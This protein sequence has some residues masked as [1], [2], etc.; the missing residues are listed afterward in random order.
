MIPLSIWRLY[1]NME[2]NLELYSRY[3]SLP[4]LIFFILIF[5]IFSFERVKPNKF[6]RKNLLCSNKNSALVFIGFI[7]VYFI[8]LRGYINTDW[9]AYYEAFKTI[10]INDINL[11]NE[12]LFWILCLISKKIFNEYSIFILLSTVLDYFLF[13]LAFK[14]EKSFSLCF[15]I[16]FLFSGGTGFRIEVN[17]MRNVKSILIFTISLKYLYSKNFKIY[18]LLNLIGSLF[19]I[20]SFIYLILPLFIQKKYNPKLTLFIFLVG[21]VI[22]LLQIHFLTNL[23]E[24]IS[25]LIPTGRLKFLL[26]VYLNSDRFSQSKTLSLGYLER[27][28]IFIILFHYSK[29]L[30]RQ[31]KKNL[32]LLNIS[33]LYIFCYLFCTEMIIITDRFTL[34]FLPGLWLLLPKIYFILNKKNKITYICILFLYFLLKYFLAIPPVMLKYDNILL[35]HMSMKER[36]WYIKKLYN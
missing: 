11:K 16:Y 13:I 22:C 6:Q 29:P 28:I 27:I 36:L 10:T 30:I 23:L 1:Q 21:N 20:T 17:L 3:Y 35:H 8:G 15:L 14:D 5:T 7:F 19:H 34:L 24:L 25:N 9:P 33:Y 31:D 12:P 2:N 32:I 26:N 4:Y 18:V